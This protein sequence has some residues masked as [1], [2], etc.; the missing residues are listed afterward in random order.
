M[1]LLKVPTA[2][3][4]GKFSRVCFIIISAESQL[5]LFDVS[6]PCWPWWTDF[7]VAGSSTKH[8]GDN[9]WCPFRRFLRLG[10][11]HFSIARISNSELQR[12]HFLFWTIHFLWFFMK[13][14]AWNWRFENV[15]LC[16]DL[17][18]QRI[19]VDTALE[20]PGLQQW[21]LLQG[22]L[23]ALYHLFCCSIC[24]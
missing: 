16:L 2:G 12:I 8:L 1:A 19:F 22:V 14:D 5:Q 18:W 7:N 9:C 6:A 11:E 10:A 4:C 15:D 17:S 24:N 21:R 3:L 23:E 13:H 20:I